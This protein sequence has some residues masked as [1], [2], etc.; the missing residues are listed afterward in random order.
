ME[1]KITTCPVCGN[2]YF[3]EDYPKCP[4]CAGIIKKQGE[5]EAMTEREF[6]MNGSGTL[7]LYTPETVREPKVET[8]ADFG[9]TMPPDHASPQFVNGQQSYN[10]DGRTRPPY[11]TGAVQKPTV[12]PYTPVSDVT[13]PVGVFKDRERPTDYIVGWLVALNGKNV[14]EDYKIRGFST[15][16][17]R[18]RDNVIV[19]VGDDT[20]SRDANCVIRYFSETKKYFIVL[21]QNVRNAIYINGEGLVSEAELHAYDVI[22]IGRTELLF[23]PLCG[24]EFNWGERVCK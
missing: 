11:D 22:K 3:Q 19:L 7:P 21:G 20:V 16:V 1:L 23:V 12:P 10:D 13:V 14:G 17:G 18:G 24:R 5:T 4:V 9:K 8:E 15:T 6:D 2:R